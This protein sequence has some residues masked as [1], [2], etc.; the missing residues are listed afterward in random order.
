MLGFLHPYRIEGGVA[1]TTMRIILRYFNTSELTRQADL[2]RSIGQSLEKEFPGAGVDVVITPQYRN[3]AEGLI[4]E[5][6]AAAF[7][8]EA[9]RRAGVEPSRT[10]V[11]GGTDG[12]RLTEMGLPTPIFRQAST[13]LTLRWNG[14]AWKKCTPPSGLFASWPRFG[15]NEGNWRSSMPTPPRVSVA[16][17]ALLVIDVQEKLLPKIAG[18]DKLVHNLSF[19]LEAG[20]WLAFRCWPPSSIPRGSGGRCLACCRFCPC[21]GKK[22]TSVVVLCPS[23]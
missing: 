20:A 14:P 22:R 6:R 7:A 11:R 2:L 17:T 4:R 13:I 15:Q 12:S 21:A 16:D 1:E 18:A 10:S 9:M 19:L 5:P 23:C 3:M 8:E